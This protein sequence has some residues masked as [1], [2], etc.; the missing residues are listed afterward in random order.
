MKDER[1]IPASCMEY[2]I[3]VLKEQR[4]LC[5]DQMHT[6]SLLNKAEDEIMAQAKCT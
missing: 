4:R 6:H 2:H 1:R 3:T 5:Y